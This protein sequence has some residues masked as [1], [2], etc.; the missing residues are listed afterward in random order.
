[1]RIA[2]LVFAALIATAVAVS[3]QTPYI[4]VYFDPGLSDE[5]KDCPG[6]VPDNLYV[7]GLNFNTFV[8]GAEF[9]VQYPAAMAWLG[10][11][12]LPPVSVGTTPS[13]ISLG[14]TAPQNGFVPIHMCTVSIFWQCTCC[15]GIENSQIKVVPNPN[16]GFLGFTD[17]PQFNLIPA[18]GLTAFVCATV[19]AEETTWGQVKAL[20]GE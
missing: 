11:A 16:T 13:G 18:V 20:Y 7:A 4:A 8:T 10:D 6:P 5:T 2:T 14:W 9:A 3:A 17:Y 1:M 15:C 12:N 19:P